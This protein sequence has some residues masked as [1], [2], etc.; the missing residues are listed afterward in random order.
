MST[1]A[2]LHQPFHVLCMYSD[3]FPPPGGDHGGFDYTVY[4]GAEQTSLHAFYDTGAGQFTEVA[5]PLS[6]DSLTYI[7]KLA[8]NIVAEFPQYVPRRVDAQPASRRML[9]TRRCWLCLMCG[10]SAEP[11]LRPS[12]ASST[13]RHGRW[14]T[15][16]R[17]SARFMYVM[18]VLCVTPSACRVRRRR[19]WRCVCV[20]NSPLNQPMA[21]PYVAMSQQLIRQQVA[22]AGYRLAQ[23]LDIAFG[24]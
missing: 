2:D 10:V 15:S 18:G 17:T 8:T 13:R 3:V 12:L 19:L 23:L 1:V 9:P 20:Q 16:S 4:N 14:T 22:L 7:T 11:R 5:R 6:D 24:G 21:T